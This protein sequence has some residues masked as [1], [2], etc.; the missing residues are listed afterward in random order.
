MAS[1]PP[2]GDYDERLLT[3]APKATK[4]ELQEGYNVNL[5]GSDNSDTPMNARTQTAR[6]GNASLEAVTP[7]TKESYPSYS[8]PWYRQGKWRVFMLVGA[9]IVIAV[10]VGGAVGGTVNH[11]SNN[12]ISAPGTGPSTTLSEVPLPI[13]SDNPIVSSLPPTSTPLG[14]QLSSNSSPTPTSTPISPQQPTPSPLPSSSTTGAATSPN[15][16]HLPLHAG[17][18]NPNVVIEVGA[19]VVV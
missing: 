11:K 18:D 3:S 6:D 13:T 10:V 17:S 5:L 15:T 12:K 7:P 14:P 1:Y 19:A 16:S 8:V 2:G 4:A 9:I